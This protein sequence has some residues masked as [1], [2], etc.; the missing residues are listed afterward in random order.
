[1]KIDP[2][3]TS[4]PKK[5]PNPIDVVA[6][7]YF[8]KERKWQANVEQT[9]KGQGWM[10][11][12]TWNSMRSDPGYPDLHLVLPGVASVFAELKTENGELTDNQI[13]W[14]LA[15]AWT[16]ETVFV[17]RP[18]D[19]DEIRDLISDCHVLSRQFDRTRELTK[20]V[21]GDTI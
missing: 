11:Y 13:R 1:M 2:N 14:L 4:I 19:G 8:P 16:G 21:G 15:L 20:N 7:D 17:W 9:F 6:H 10:C 12:H 5:N 18:S 3:V